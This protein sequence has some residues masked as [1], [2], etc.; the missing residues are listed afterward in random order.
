MTTGHFSDMAKD[1]YQE[2]VEDLQEDHSKKDV[3]VTS[4]CRSVRVFIYFQQITA[5]PFSKESFRCK[6]CKTDTTGIDDVRS[7]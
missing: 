2:W 3:T 1:L 7:Y 6:S 4:Y 5:A